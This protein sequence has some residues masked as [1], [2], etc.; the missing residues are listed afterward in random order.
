[1]ELGGAWLRKIWMFSLAGR[2]SNACK[3]VALMTWFWMPRM[4]LWLQSPVSPSRWYVF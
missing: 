1:M 2:A 3:T 4:S